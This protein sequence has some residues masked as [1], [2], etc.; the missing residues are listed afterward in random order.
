[1]TTQ[2]D[3][4]GCRFFDP[5]RDTSG[6][7]RRYAPQPERSIE[8]DEG[9]YLPH[10]ERNR[11]MY[12]TT[13]TTH[14]EAARQQWR[15]ARPVRRGQ[16]N[17][18]CLLP[19]L[20]KLLAIDAAEEQAVAQ[21]GASVGDAS[22]PVRLPRPWTAAGKERARGGRP[23]PWTDPRMQPAGRPLRSFHIRT[24]LIPAGGDDAKEKFP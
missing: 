18:A 20:A 2:A 13:P 3:C 14:R 8:T 1:M 4:R 6:L 5:S 22:G 7:C 19:P 10:R 9:E 15:T 21:A 17:P 23:G 24:A 11:L 12:A 16:I